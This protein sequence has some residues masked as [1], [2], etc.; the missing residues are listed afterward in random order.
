MTNFPDISKW[1]GDVDFDV[2]V[3]KT[4]YIILKAGQGNWIDPKFTRNKT[5]CLRVGLNF[6]VYWFYDD[7]HSPGKQA[8]KLVEILAGLQP[9]EIFCD[10]ESTYGGNYGGLQNVVAFMQ[11]VEELTQ[12]AVGM[13][14]GYY[15]FVENSNQNQN[16]NQYAYLKQRALWLAWYTPDFSE[17]L[18]PAPWTQTSIWQYGTPPIAHEYGVT[19]SKEI[20]MNERMG[21]NPPDPEPTPD[22]GGD[23][24]EVTV[25][26]TQG[27][28]VKNNPN[29]GGNA[30]HIYQ[31]DE[32]F[33]AS[34][35]VAD[36]TDP[37]NPQKRWAKIATGP[38]KDKHVA[39]L[40]PSSSSGNVRCIWRE[41]DPDPEPEPNPETI[42]VSIEMDIN[43]QTGE[44]SNVVINDKPYA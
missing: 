41:L 20:D 7:R 22:P 17:V 6:G 28:S 25:V 31:K 13:Y 8:E 3:T 18:I 44:P 37:N 39:V 38:Y 9:S 12:I 26:W 43:V 2:M 5:E 15:W 16:K 24:L 23:M 34:D 1:Q 30:L 10:W 27:A 29:T 40:Y 11:R 21:E 35:I 33:L 19:E 42:H 32:K 36:N 4:D 14:T